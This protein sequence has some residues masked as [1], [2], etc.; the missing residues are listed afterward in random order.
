MCVFQR[1]S[2]EELSKDGSLQC[3]VRYGV[4]LILERQRLGRLVSN[5]LR[6]L[7]LVG[8]SSS[9]SR[10]AAPPRARILL[11]HLPPVGA[12]LR[13]LTSRV[14]HHQR[15][16]PALSQ[17]SVQGMKDADIA[18]TV[19]VEM[20]HQ[21][22]QCTGISK[23]NPL[24]GQQLGARRIANCL[25]LRGQAAAHQSEPP[26][27]RR[28]GVQTGLDG[29]ALTAKNGHPINHDGVPE[30]QESPNVW[31][32]RLGVKFPGLRK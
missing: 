15:K 22:R 16:P 26:R 8:Q 29:G 11:A 2:S 21:R 31:G 32:C 12:P 3:C 18:I 9:R 23:R 19:D 4:Q 14:L 20:N 27:A 17:K 28:E 1:G 13:S 25:T 7:A 6:Q 24:Q 10:Q 30:L 5:E